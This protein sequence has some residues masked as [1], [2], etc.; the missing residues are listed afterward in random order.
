MDWDDVDSKS[1]SKVRDILASKYPPGVVPIVDTMEEYVTMP[2]LVTL[3]ITTDK[4][5]KVSRKMSG[6]AGPRGVD[7]VGIYHCTLRFD[8]VSGRLR[9]TMID[10][11]CWLGNEPPPWTAYSNGE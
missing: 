7:V 2:E 1:G 3:D 8:K 6:L 9:G 11:C 5:E 10:L 4:V